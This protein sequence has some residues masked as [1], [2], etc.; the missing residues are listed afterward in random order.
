MSFDS[1][2]TIAS[3]VPLSLGCI[4]ILS[5]TRASF[6]PGKR[7]GFLL[8]SILTILRW[9]IPAAIIFFGGLPTLKLI[10]NNAIYISIFISLSLALFSYI[11]ISAVLKKTFIPK[12]HFVFFNSMV[13]AFSK[14]QRKIIAHHEAG[15]LVLHSAC[16]ESALPPFL[17]A[18]ITKGL[19]G[20]AGYVLSFPSSNKMKFPSKDYLTWECL[21]LLAGDLSTEISLGKR[22]I[23]ASSDLESWYSI[24]TKMLRNGLTDYPFPM[25][26]ANA[27][28]RWLSYSNLLNDHRKIVTLFLK[29]NE[30][31]INEISVKL[32]RKGKLNFKECRNFLSYAQNIELLPAISKDICPPS[33]KRKIK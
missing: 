26:S 8:A 20:T 29:S 13:P 31:L 23:G 16:H 32:D 10:W 25:G 24:A 18:R 7:V 33:R 15:H 21:M 11:I 3:L 30:I 17:E 5:Q 9:G 19:T 22:Y 2:F 27:E 14:D 12:D 6:V 1:V 28:V 4:I